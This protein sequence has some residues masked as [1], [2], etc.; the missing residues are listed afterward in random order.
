LA[1]S[2][3]AWSVGAERCG[4]ADWV[5]ASRNRDLA[6]ISADFVPDLFMVGFA[7]VGTVVAARRPFNAIGWFLLGTGLVEAARGL[8]GEY[9][10]HALTGPPHPTGV[11]A[12]WF[13]NW[14]LGLLV[15]VGVLAFLMLLFPD[16]RPPT[17]R[18]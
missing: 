11:W 1:L 6:D 16:S 10:R 15:P 17:R 5:R 14:S 7:L 13:V 2:V 18:W 4:L 9:A 8:T 3:L 12:E